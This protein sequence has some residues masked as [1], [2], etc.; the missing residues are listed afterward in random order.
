[1][2]HAIVLA[3]AT[4]VIFGAAAAPAGN[5]PFGCDARAG[6]TCVFKIFL[7]PRATRIVQLRSGMKV[8]IPGMNIGQDSYCVDIGKTPVHKCIRKIVNA[9][10]NN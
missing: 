10:Y 5:A 4:L 1:M 9:G 6:Q 8:T 7:G 2:R 3:L